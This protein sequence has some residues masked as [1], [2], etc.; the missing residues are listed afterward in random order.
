MKL[1]STF[2]SRVG[3]DGFTLMELLMAVFIFAVLMLGGILFVHVHGL[4]MFQITEKKLNVLTWSRET[5]TRLTD[6]VRS[7]SDA[8]VG[9]LDTNGIFSGLSDGASQEGNALLIYPTDSLTNYITYFVNASNQLLRATEDPASARILARSVTN[10]LPFS[11]QDAAG[12]VATNRLNNGVIHVV[13]EFYQPERF[14]QSMD[15]YKL[16]TSVARRILP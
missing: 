13:L 6:E 4:K 7:C 12:D 1:S 16:E 5:V 8:K 3:V 14:M 10:S 11:L 15:Y 2:S 9:N